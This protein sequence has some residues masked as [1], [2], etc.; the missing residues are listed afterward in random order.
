M[1]CAVA[2]L[3]DIEWSEGSYD[4]LKIP[5]NK[6]KMLTA[7]ATTRLGRIQTV[8]FGDVIK[9]KGCGLNVLL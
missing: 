3:S 4:C 2:D 5:E 9:G 8:P 7:L 1:E 6:K